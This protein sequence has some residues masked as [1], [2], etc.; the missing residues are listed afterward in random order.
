MSEKQ[1]EYPYK[2]AISKYIASVIVCQTM[3]GADCELLNWERTD[4]ICPGCNCRILVKIQF[5]IKTENEEDVESD[6][7]T[8]CPRCGWLCC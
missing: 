4:E 5:L 3:L 7:D 8:I 1:T 6:K 2:N